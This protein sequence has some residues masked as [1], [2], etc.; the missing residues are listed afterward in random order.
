METPGNPEERYVGNYNVAPTQGVFTVYESSGERLLDRFHWGLV[1]FW[2]KDPSIGS[3]MINARAE[4]LAEKNSF[5]RPFA[6]KR[7]IIPA[8]GFYEWKKSAAKKQ[9]V[10]ISQTV[11]LFAIGAEAG[12]EARNSAWAEA[13][14]EYRRTYWEVCRENKQVREQWDSEFEATASATRRKRPTT[15]TGSPR[16]KSSSRNIASKSLLPPLCADNPCCSGGRPG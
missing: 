14:S 1:P 13:A 6:T 9:P 8:D 16:G 4:T 3:K 2:A 11:G 12:E 15:G 10:F 5:K 7:C